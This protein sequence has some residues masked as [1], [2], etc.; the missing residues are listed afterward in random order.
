MLYNFQRCLE[1]LLVHEGGYSDH[2][3]DPGGVT[4]LGVTK[5][6]YENY[7]GRSVST[8]EMKSLNQE[9]VAPIYKTRYW[10]KCQGD[11]LPSGVDLMVFDWAVNSGP[12]RAS[13]ALQKAVR[14][15]ADGAIGP[16]TLAAVARSNDHETIAEIYAQRNRFYRRL[17]T[18]PTFGRGWLRRSDETFQIATK[19]VEC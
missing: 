16:N 13:R 14:S 4:M 11:S 10:D 18:F 6:T 7:V 15:R 19:M 1:L 12:R 17:K 3:E 9:L 2:R 5:T 8:S